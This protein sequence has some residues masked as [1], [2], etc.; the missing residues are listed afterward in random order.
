MNKK[1]KLLEGKLLGL[2]LEHPDYPLI[3]MVDGDGDCEPGMWMQ[4]TITQIEEEFFVEGNT[5]RWFFDD[6]EEAVLED[7]GYGIGL[8][9]GEVTP[10]EAETLFYNLDWKKGI[11]L[12][13]T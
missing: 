4:G 10:E 3:P 8:N 13:I 11:F 5:Q 1:Q 6:P 7:L 2:M 9:P 12:Y